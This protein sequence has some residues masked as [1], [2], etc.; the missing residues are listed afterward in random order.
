MVGLCRLF[1]VCIIALRLAGMDWFDAI[2][3]AF[4]AMSLGGFPRMTAA[5]V[6]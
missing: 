6:F 3:H 1:S 2:C 5:S 4:A